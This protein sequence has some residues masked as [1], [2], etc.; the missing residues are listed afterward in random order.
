MRRGELSCCSLNV[1]SKIAFNLFSFFKL[2]IP[3][4][5]LLPFVSLTDNLEE[6][7]LFQCVCG[8][9]EGGKG[10]LNHVWLE[11]HWGR[12]RDLT[13]YLNYLPGEGQRPIFRPYVGLLLALGKIRAC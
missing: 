10:Y 1:K 7:G 4:L 3:F 12:R 2:A 9:G 13:Q 11:C 5:F 8:G 6:E